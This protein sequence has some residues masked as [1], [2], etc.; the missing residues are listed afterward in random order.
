MPRRFYA[1]WA[2]VV[3][4]AL[5]LPIVI[6]FAVWPP[7]EG[8]QSDMVAECGRRAEN[9]AASET[10]FIWLPLSS[11]VRFCERD[12]SGFLIYRAE[13]S[14]RGPYGIPYASGTVGPRDVRHL[15]AHGGVALG[16]A[17][18]LA[19]V[20]AVSAP[21]ALILL[22]HMRRSRLQSAP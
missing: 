2:L 10:P 12:E 1:A 14:A 21:F 5:V 3:L 8:H 7:R 20:T 22:R 18:L 11:E 13:V 19:S 16:V 15:R 6:P 17:A 4:L 9:N